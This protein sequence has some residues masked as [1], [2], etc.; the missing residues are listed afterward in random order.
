M[1][2]IRNLSKNVIVLGYLIVFALFAM[3]RL[4]LK[5]F[6]FFISE[7]ISLRKNYKDLVFCFEFGS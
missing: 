1:K 7:K 2:D 3:F 6:I 5:K 4:E